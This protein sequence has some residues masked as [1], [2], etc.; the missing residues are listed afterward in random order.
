MGNS[1]LLFPYAPRSLP[2]LR[3]G[4]WGALASDL[5]RTAREAERLHAIAIADERV[6]GRIDIH[7]NQIKAAARWMKPEK[8]IVRRS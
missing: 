1:A 6:L 4:E 5:N 7:L 2:P 8:W 3:V